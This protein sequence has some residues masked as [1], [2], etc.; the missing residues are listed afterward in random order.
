MIQRIYDITLGI[1]I[2]IA[3]GVLLWYILG[4][5]PTT[6]QLFI[7]LMIALLI[8]VLGQNNKNTKM[9]YATREYM[10]REFSKIRL[11]SKK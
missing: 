7:P 2:I 11:D 8:Y 10:F 5:S 1:S 3:I 4:N 9:I 6:E